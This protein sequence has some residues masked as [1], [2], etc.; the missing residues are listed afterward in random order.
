MSLSDFKNDIHAAKN[1]KIITNNSLS[2]LSVSIPIDDIYVNISAS[3]YISVCFMAVKVCFSH[4]QAIE[5]HTAAGLTTY[6]IECLDY[7]E[8]EK[9]KT[10][11]FDIISCE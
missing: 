2:P 3:P 4:I 11:T 5:K 9:P 6:T 8:L 10:V 1:L 7:T